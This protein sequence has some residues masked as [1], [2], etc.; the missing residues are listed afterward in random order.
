M[1]HVPPKCLFPEEKDLG[2]GYRKNLV[3]VPSCIRHNSAKSSDDEYLLFCIT[4]NIKTN[5]LARDHVQTKVLRA[6]DRSPD[7]FRRFITGARPVLVRDGLTGKVSQTIAYHVDL[8]RLHRIFRQI[9]AGLYY[10]ENNRRFTGTYQVIINGLWSSG[11][12]AYEENEYWRVS[13]ERLK[14]AFAPVPFKGENPEVFR[15]KTTA[16]RGSF[17]IQMDFWE[18]HSV[19]VRLLEKSA[20][21]LQGGNTRAVGRE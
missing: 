6:I 10:H 8:N 18:L 11:A 15:Y 14:S 4:M 12:N 9:S 2:P 20:E 19:I 3:T 13:E 16:G 1:E 21:G 5:A 7:R 17:I